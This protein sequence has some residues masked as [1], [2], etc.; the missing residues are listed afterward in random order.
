MLR[1]TRWIRDAR[2]LLA[3]VR[4][5]PIWQ[6]L[7]LIVAAVI[8]AAVYFLWP[9][10]EGY[11]K[12]RGEQIAEPTPPATALAPTLVTVLPTPTTLEPPVLRAEWHLNQGVSLRGLTRPATSE[13]AE[14]ELTIFNDGGGDAR[15]LLV[16]LQLPYLIDS[17]READRVDADGVFTPPAPPIGDVM[18]STSYEMRIGTIRPHGAVILLVVVNAARLP[19][20]R[21]PTASP[22]NTYLVITNKLGR[23]YCVPF[24]LG[25]KTVI[26]GRDTDCPEHLSIQSGFD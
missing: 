18:L 5:L 25:G 3:W 2:E 12:K 11:L 1:L 19:F 26:E 17:V 24:D 21:A 9:M 15:G 4:R 22:A 14:Y 6:A 7:L 16:R 8:A 13:L 23:L 20:G 10:R